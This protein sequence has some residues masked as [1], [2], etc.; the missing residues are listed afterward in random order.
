MVYYL[1]EVEQKYLNLNLRPNARINPVPEELRGWNWHSPPLKP[2]YNL[3]L[4]MFLICSNYCPTSRDIYLFMVEKVRGEENFPIKLG[5]AV[6][7]AVASA[8]KE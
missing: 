6:H 4:P 5:K 8:I 3:R 2:Y 7:N 1:S